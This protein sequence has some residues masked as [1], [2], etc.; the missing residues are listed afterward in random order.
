MTE[1]PEEKGYTFKDK[2]RLFRD[3]EDNQAPE[4]T[5]P[6]KE[7]PLLQND[8]T[9]PLPTIDFATFLLSLAS[10]A[11]IQLGLTPHPE[12]NKKESHL[13]GAK[14]TID[15]LGLLQEKTK[16]NLS[17]N[18]AKLLEAI[19]YDLRMVFVTLNKKEGT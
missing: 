1:N 18:E 2:R 11:Q 7:D 6:K 12:T 9:S 10:S 15:I 19:L 3:A 8:K 16:G 5:N 17:E 4:T 14:Q 13:E